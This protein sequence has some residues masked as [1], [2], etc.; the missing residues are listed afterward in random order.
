MWEVALLC[1]VQHSE[2]TCEEVALLCCQCNIVNAREGM[3]HGFVVC[4]TVN[5]YMVKVP[6]SCRV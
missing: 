3:S 4:N 5:T 6:Q 2:Q 1:C